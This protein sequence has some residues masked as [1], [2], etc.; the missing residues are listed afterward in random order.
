MRKDP[1]VVVEGADPETC[2]R[3]DVIILAIVI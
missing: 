3:H 2:L 1:K